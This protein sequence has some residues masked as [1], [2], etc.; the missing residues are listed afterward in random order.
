M[1]SH[2]RFRVLLAAALLALFAVSSC[3]G[4][5]Q[6]PAPGSGPAGTK[7]RPAAGGAAYRHLESDCKTLNWVLYTSG[8][9]TTA[10]WTTTGTWRSF[11][12]SPGITR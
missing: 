7:S 1:F 5:D 9:S 10:F 8:F 11:P 4:R 2:G 12:C 6:K 3:G